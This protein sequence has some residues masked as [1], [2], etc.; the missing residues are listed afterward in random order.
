MPPPDMPI[1]GKWCRAV[2]PR[3]SDVTPDL[4]TSSA[5]HA[6]RE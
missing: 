5:A 2:S 6:E 3:A 1:A 4:R